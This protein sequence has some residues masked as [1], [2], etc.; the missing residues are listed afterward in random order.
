VK[1]LAQPPEKYCKSGST[2]A[3]ADRIRLI[4]G[5]SECVPQGA[6]L[7]G[8]VPERF[9]FSPLIAIAIPFQAEQHTV[10]PGQERSRRLLLS[11]TARM[12]REHL[13]TT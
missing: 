10:A 6:R 1:V 12:R 9:P 11:H 7:T 4:L 2:L 13:E 8:F 5:L 3:L